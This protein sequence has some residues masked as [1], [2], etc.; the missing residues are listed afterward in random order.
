M[1]LL[2]LD[3]EGHL[4]SGRRGVEVTGRAGNRLA[5]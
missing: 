1:M 3:L 5:R 4:V 2:Q